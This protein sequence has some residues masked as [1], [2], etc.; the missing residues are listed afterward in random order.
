M[1]PNHGR[2]TESPRRSA[3]YGHPMG[4]TTRALAGLAGAAL[5]AAGCS[6]ASSGGPAAG[7]QP[8][9]PAATVSTPNSHPTHDRPSPHPRPTHAQPTRSVDPDVPSNHRDFGYVVSVDHVSGVASLQFD[10]AILY[11]G[12]AANKAAAA[13][14]DETP[15]PNDYY[16]VNDNPKVFTFEL[17]PHVTL[18][19]SQALQGESFT[20]HSQPGPLSDLEQFVEDHPDQLSSVAFTLHFNPDNQVERIEEQYTP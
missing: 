18:M 15:V 17:A 7:P 12:E 2:E 1:V 9:T 5:F 6:G 19:E 10:R 3:G 20:G 13:H 8:G 4:T 16:I 14:G 11:T